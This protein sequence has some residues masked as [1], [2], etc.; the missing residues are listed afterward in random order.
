MPNGVQQSIVRID[1]N[2][3][4]PAEESLVQSLIKIDV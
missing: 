2:N 1:T 3:S 4:Q